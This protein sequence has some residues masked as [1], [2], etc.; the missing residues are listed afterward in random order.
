MLR[1]ECITQLRLG[2][3][4]CINIRHSNCSLGMQ[5]I[6]NS[7]ITYNYNYTNIHSYT[8]TH[9]HTHTHSQAHTRARTLT[10]LHTHTHTHTHT[11]IH[12]H[13]HHT[14]THRPICSYVNKFDVL[15]KNNLCKTYILWT[16]FKV[17]ISFFYYKLESLCYIVD[18]FRLT[19]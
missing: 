17:F 15:K 1:D 7:L 12:T 8:H 18:I 19:Y 11:L 6:V 16:V 13:T 14:Y 2:H 4:S 3:Y 10:H 9:T 5:Y